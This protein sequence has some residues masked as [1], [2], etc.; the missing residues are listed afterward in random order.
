MASRRAST[1]QRSLWSITAV[2][3]FGLVVG[4][5]RAILVTRTPNAVSEHGKM[6]PLK[7]T[8]ACLTFLVVVVFGMQGLHA[9]HN[10]DSAA[11]QQLTADG[12]G[13]LLRIAGDA[14]ALHVEV[15]QTTIADVLSALESFNLRYRS[16]IG[17]DEVVNGS[18][19]GSLGHVVA[20]LLNGYNYAIK[21]ASSGLEVTIFGKGDVFAVPAPIIIPVRRRPSD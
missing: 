7:P 15:Q 2:A 13:R 19:A 9:Q 16:S 8:A 11:P 21:L 14:A 12:G 6:R 5:I 20:R 10:P 17:L 3:K 18:Y 4:S 1:Q